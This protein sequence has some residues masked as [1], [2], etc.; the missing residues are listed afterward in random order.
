MTVQLATSMASPRSRAS[1]KIDRPACDLPT[2]AKRA[3]ETLMSSLADTTGQVD[4]HVS[5]G[6]PHLSS[7]C[8]PLPGIQESLLRSSQQETAHKPSTQ[9]HCGQLTSKAS[10]CQGIPCLSAW[11]STP[12]F[13]SC[14]AY[15]PVHVIKCSSQAG[16]LRLQWTTHQPLHT[17]IDTQTRESPSVFS[18]SPDLSLA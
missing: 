18:R 1:L 16:C 14:Q 15:L 13:T 11:A 5:T 9:R 2:S 6:G 12:G 8:R 7:L 4:S 17:G 3:L 10:P